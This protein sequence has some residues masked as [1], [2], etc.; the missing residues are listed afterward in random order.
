MGRL[1]LGTFV[2]L[3][4]NIE[5]INYPFI[6]RDKAKPAEYDAGLKLAIERCS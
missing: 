4:S 1:P 6:D 2:R 5:K 3:R